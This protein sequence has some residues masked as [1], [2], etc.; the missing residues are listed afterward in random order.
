MTDPKGFLTI[1]RRLAPYRPVDERLKDYR[2]VVPEADTA[3]VREQARRCMDCGV[4]F[5]QPGCPLGNLIPDW[6]DLVERDHFK[7][8]IDS[9]HSTNNFP[10][11]T[12]AICPA[13]CEEA[14]VLALVGQPVTIK[15]VEMSIIERAYA[16]GWVQPRPAKQRSSRRVA[17]VGSGPA[18]LACA[19]ELV[20]K[21]HAVTVFERDDRLGGLLRFGIPDFKMEKHLI[22][23]RLEQLEAEGI[24]FATSVEV[25][26][27]LSIEELQSGVDV[28]VLATGAQRHRDIEL[29]G[30]EL[31]GVEFAMPYLIQQNRR[32]AGLP[33]DGP[34]ITAKGKRVAI[35]GGGDTS[36]DCLGN[37]L[38]EEA[39]EVH[40][41]AHGPTPP[42]QRDPQ[43]TWP[44]WPVVLRTYGAHQEGGQREWQFV[45]D[46]FEGTNGTVQRLV[47]HRV[48]FPD[49]AATGVRT[50][51]AIA[52][53]EVVLDVDLVLLAIGFTGIE[54][55]DVY[56]Q[57]GVTINQRGTV[58]INRAYE[59]AT[60]GIYACGDVR[61]GADLVVT[62]IADGRKCAAAVHAAI[63]A[64][65]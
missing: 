9:L 63:S 64:D 62:A 29:S 12:G 33:I 51:V 65:H 35:L 45:T 28:V 7:D 50:P 18:G 31:A 54:E 10:E 42:G 55:D 61:R 5:C 8:A 37:A 4:P 44:E 58:T 1:Q 52:G 46:R 19:Q 15:Q 53:G 17:I 13:P 23:R 40:E 39:I 60:P 24:E 57:S 49:Y 11:F 14:C 34:E 20:R 43:K 26:R 3:L 16:E 59:T 32:Q 38:R 56:A 25:G 36:A 27:D 41:I 22:D 21:G 48:E 30:R 6:N 2:A 47:G